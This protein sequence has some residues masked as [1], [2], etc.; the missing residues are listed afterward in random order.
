MRILLAPDMKIVGFFYYRPIKLLSFKL[1]C[2]Y[3]V[4]NS[5]IRKVFGK[6]DYSN[7]P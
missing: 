2:V 7:I 4:V 1:F 3:L 6:V 5:V